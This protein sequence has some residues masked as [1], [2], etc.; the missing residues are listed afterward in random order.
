MTRLFEPLQIGMCSLKHR[1]VMAPMTRL[2]ADDEHVPP[3]MMVEYYSQRA[4]VPGTLIIT[5][6]NF[7]AA[8]S[9]GRDENAP[10]I[11]T[12]AQIDHWRQVTREVHDRGSFIYVQLW[13][14]GRAARK[15]ALEKAGLEMLSSSAI[16][17]SAEHPTPRPMTEEEIQ[18][19]I[20]DFAQAA[21]NAIEAG[22]DGVE[23]HGANGYLIDQFTQ[24]TCNQRTDKW[25]GSIENRSRF[26]LEIVRAVCD[27][28]GP[29]RTGIRLSPF[30]T[31][32]GM[33][34]ED[35]I[36]QFTYLISKLKTFGLSYLHL[37]EPRVSG[38]VDL[39]SKT[40][41][42]DSLDFARAAWQK[43]SPIILAGG[44]TPATASQALDTTL[45]DGDIAIAFGRFFISNPDLP[46]R[47][48]KNLALTPY[49]RDTFYKVKSPNGYIDYGFSEEWLQEKASNHT[50]DLK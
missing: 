25:G 17:I 31:F 29:E 16:P 32:Q 11:F 45:K 13:H 28:I 22:F 27:A 49:Q 12:Q 50:G 35:P 19:C 10:G 8:R 36:P 43:C 5:E 30:S 1:I 42:T 47:A 3:E 39:H 37:I 2:R 33:R 40:L 46:Y 24:D 38:N 18:N 7:I 14:V 20:D 44:Y 48:A 41:E 4:S 15:S 34:M 26:C 6:S 9:R 21:E 23:I